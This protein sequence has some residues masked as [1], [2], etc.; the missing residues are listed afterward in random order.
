M[1]YRTLGKVEKDIVVS[2]ISTH[3]KGLFV[4]A[5]TVVG[6][7]GSASWYFAKRPVPPPLPPV[8]C[9]PMVVD[10]ASRVSAECPP[11]STIEI[12]GGRFAVCACPSNKVAPGSSSEVVVDENEQID[13]IPEG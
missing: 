1:T 10:M 13:P 2:W 12:R 3:W 4:I 11:G 5:F 9:A 6:L 7:A 8:P